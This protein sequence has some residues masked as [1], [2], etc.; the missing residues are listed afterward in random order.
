MNR[1]QRSRNRFGFTSMKFP[2]I[3]MAVVVA[4]VLGIAGF[5]HGRFVDPHANRTHFSARQ[6][7]QR[8]NAICTAACGESD[9]TPMLHYEDQTIGAPQN[10]RHRHTWTATCHVNGRVITIMFNDKTGNVAS[11]FS[12]RDQSDA[13]QIMERHCLSTKQ[14]ALQMSVHWLR[15]LNMT[16]TGT[17][18]ELESIVT[19]EARR[20]NWSIRWRVANPGVHDLQ[21]VLI[22]LNQQTGFP[23]VI[24]NKFEITQYAD[25]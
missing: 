13:A 5:L 10:G 7:E 1:L 12:F 16:P 14:D 18:I 6:I 15:A 21:P 24:A 20:E 9:G 25:Q 17:R 22:S 23:T 8:A 3:P 4:M 19:P 2:L 11:V